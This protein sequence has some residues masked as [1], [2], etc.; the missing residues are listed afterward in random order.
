MD[1]ERK[2]IMADHN[3]PTV[4]STYTNFVAELDGRLDDLALMYD[5]ATTAPT[6][7]QVNAVRWSSVAGK[8]QKWNGTAWNDLSILYNINIS[9]NSGTVTNG[10]YTVGNQTI[11]GNKTF[12]GTVN[13]SSDVSISLVNVGRGGSN[14][15]TNT[16]VGANALVAN[17]TGNN[18][19][20]SGS[21][22]LR[23]NTTGSN[24]TASGANALYSNTSGYSNIANGTSA[25]YNNTT[26]SNNVAS[27]DSALLNNTAGGENTAIGARA[28]FYNTTGYSNTAN[29]YSALYRN[30]TGDSNTANGYNALYSNTTGAYNTST[31][32]SALYS[33]TTGAGNTSF[34]HDALYSNTTGANNTSTGRGALYSN[35]T[36]DAN[37]AIGWLALYSSTTGP[38]NTASGTQALYSNT[39]GPNNTAS[40]FQ[41][42]YYNTTG[43]GNTASGYKTLY[44]N[45]TGGGN[46]ASGYRSLYSNTT[47]FNNTAS[48]T[49]ALFSNTT[50]F[51]NT[52]FGTNALSN[53]GSYTNC[54]G[55]GSNTD[56]TNSSQVQL[57]DS[58]TT[59]YVYGT[60]QNRSDLR[61][62]ADIRD[63]LL[64]LE[65]INGL[66]AVDYR[67]DMR[68]DYKP[69]MPVEDADNP[70]T[71]ED[72]SKWRESCKLAN[73]KRD[74]SKKRSRYH[75]G[76]IAQDVKALVDK[77]GI[78]F[79]GLQDHSLTGGDDVLSIGYDELI[80]P[81]I[82]AVQELSAR[83]VVLES[84]LS[85]LES[86]S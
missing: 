50:G 6:N 83:I 75:H 67:W 70:L 7:V 32:H 12:T 78:D 48:G 47:G 61:D 79:G 23:S 42:L 60:V 43:D 1:S 14:Q 28:L 5:P 21:S 77:H 53:V 38:N 15:S 57:G 31:G 27:G 13:T 66:R 63:T 34:G 51:S 37:T 22:A 86:K 25:L 3:K 72:I 2:L 9:G 11:A 64:G 81:L 59:T 17:T 4:D 74:G 40:G 36:A 84:K 76:L 85:T 39:T 73:I 52:A 16:V 44:S 19:V 30:T 82:K 18:N 56:V 62:K 49:Y 20:A 26:G 10:V 54:S 71:E 55:F 8:F 33:N 65:F 45:T 41:A 46:T 69:A 58:S 29:G 35:T 24:N 80:A 68:E